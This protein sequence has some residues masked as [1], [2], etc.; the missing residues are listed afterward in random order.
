MNKTHTTQ[1]Q[2]EEPYEILNTQNLERMSAEIPDKD[3]D[4]ITIPE[5][6]LLIVD[7]MRRL[8]RNNSQVK[9]WLQQVFLNVI[10]TGQKPIFN[11]DNKEFNKLAKELYRKKSKKWEARDNKTR[12]HCNELTFKTA[13][14]EGEIFAYYDAAGIISPG[15]W[16]YWKRE[17]MP[18]INKTDF[19]EH[20]E[21]IKKIVGVKPDT[22][23]KQVKGLITDDWGITKGYIICKKPGLG[24]AKYD[25]ENPERNKITIIPASHNAKLIKFTEEMNA[26]HGVSMLIALAEEVNNVKRLIKAFVNR[27]EMQARIAMLFKTKNPF[28]KQ[29]SRAANITANKERGPDDESI[30][31]KNFEK[32]AKDFN[33]FAEYMLLDEEVEFKNLMPGEAKEV[34]AIYSQVTNQAGFGLGLS[35]MH[36][37]GSSDKA[38]FA[39]LMAEANISSKTFDYLQKYVEREI[40]DFET[41]AVIMDAIENKELPHVEDWDKI[42]WSGWPKVQA[43][44]PLQNIKAIKEWLSAG[45]MPP[46]EIR[47]DLIDALKALSEF[48]NNAEKLGLKLDIFEGSTTEEDPKQEEEENLKEE[49]E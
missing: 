30:R 36:T 9:G 21:R 46:D 20:I 6:D 14:V 4:E 13:Y 47:G 27:T 35:R 7:V 34:E 22:E 5:D 16:L 39:G 44:N 18:M 1:T 12:Y 29:A 41:E 3:P 15:K 19:K 40:Y 43:L 49:G 25:P 32:M 42:S 26:K 2:F 17:Y 45:L 24:E 10:C 11:S 48:K 33:A 28:K 37:S 8:I 23:L 31:F 38:S